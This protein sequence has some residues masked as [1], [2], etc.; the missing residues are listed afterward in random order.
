MF[1]T[2]ERL[3]AP[4]N[5]AEWGAPPTATTPP[6]TLIVSALGSI[7]AVPA[8]VRDSA[9]K[10]MSFNFTTVTGRRIVPVPVAMAVFGA[11][12]ASDDCAD[13]AR[14]AAGRIQGWV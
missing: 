11:A 2:W 6:V 14:A 8:A 4:A 10:S 1:T 3:A 13:S 5:S 7:T 9:P 12:V